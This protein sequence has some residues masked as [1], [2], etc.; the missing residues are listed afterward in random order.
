MKLKTINNNKIKP[1]FK[2]DYFLC[3]LK[4]R[5]LNFIIYVIFFKYK[6]FVLKSHDI[7]CSE[8]T[9]YNNGVTSAF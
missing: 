8:F 3:I 7:K 1:Y 4:I 5:R 2:F 9:Q 6:Y